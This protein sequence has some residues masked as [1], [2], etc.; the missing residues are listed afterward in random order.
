MTDGEQAQGAAT[1][2]E[3]GAFLGRIL[4]EV[5]RSNITLPTAIQIYE[6]QRMPRAW[7]KQQAS[8]VSGALNMATES[9]AQRRNKASAPE[10][11]AWNNDVLKP[12]KRLPPSYRSWQM[13]P[14]PESVPGIL[15]YDAEC[16]ADNAV[17]EWLQ[18]NTEKD[19]N[20]LVT[21]GIWDKWWGVVD[22]NGIDETDPTQ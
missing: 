7:I 2:M 8:F 13:F 5:I 19:W 15:Y 22:F 4:S 18:K 20:T 14:N 21:K 1:A 3:D 10:V 11:E 6:Q 9:D 17:C 16:D 12:M